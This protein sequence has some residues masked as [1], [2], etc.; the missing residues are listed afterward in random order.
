MGHP[1][2]AMGHDAHRSWD[3]HCLFPF[4]QKLVSR[5]CGM[6]NDESEC[7]MNAGGEQVAK[8]FPELNDEAQRGSK[9]RC[10]LLTD[11]FPTEVAG[12]L[13][14][15]VSPHGFVSS[16]LCWAPD[17]FDDVE[18]LQIQKPNALISDEKSRELEDWWFV[19]P[20]GSAPSWDLASQCTI[21]KGRGAR[22][23]V[24]LVEAKAH[25][26]ELGSGGKQLDRKATAESRQ[27][28]Q[29]IG[30]AIE[31]ANRDL[32]S[33]TGLKAWGLSRD[34]CYQMSNR[35]AWSWKLACLGTPVVLVYLGFLNAIEMSDKGD[36]FSEHADWVDC[37]KEQAQ[38]KVPE[39][40]WDHAWA[41][42]NGA[43]F[44]PRIM[45][46]HQPLRAA[47]LPQEKLMN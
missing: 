21:G 32:R 29:H 20:R 23:G 4:R 1:T 13:T 27:N 8:R 34:S 2:L 41:L 26:A 3:T 12:R 43:V 24:L 46:V 7:P 45:S 28:H 42:N 31:E 44:V 22:R 18:E 15:L 11:G 5:L 25:R 16:R 30:E 38:G 6:P 17:G 37:V 40:A 10:H 19:T 9:P 39:D 47:R 36:P 33:I 35:F 14:H